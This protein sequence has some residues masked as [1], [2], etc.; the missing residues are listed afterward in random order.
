VVVTLADEGSVKDAHP[1][2][3]A[4][5][6]PLS[7]AAASGIHLWIAIPAADRK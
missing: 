6:V 2:A 5:Q 7:A 4:I 3:S 1:P